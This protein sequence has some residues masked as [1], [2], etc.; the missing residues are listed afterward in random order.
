MAK[1]CNNSALYGSLEFCQG[2]TVLPGLRK[3]VYFIP[4][5]SIVKYPTLPELSA[6]SVD[7]AALATYNGDF[8]LAADAKWKSID[9]LT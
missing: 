2:T 8:T 4:K 9:V 1:V 5:A 6:E 7:M 3:R